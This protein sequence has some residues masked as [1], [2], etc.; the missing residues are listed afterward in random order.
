MRVVGG[1]PEDFAGG[2]LVRQDHVDRRA[3]QVAVLGVAAFVGLQGDVLAVVEEQV[4]IVP[5]VQ[6]VAVA[7]VIDVLGNPPPERVVR[8]LDNLRDIAQIVLLGDLGQLVAVVPGV[9]G[10]FTGGKVAIISRRNYQSRTERAL[11]ACPALTSRPRDIVTV[12]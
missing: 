4:D 1:R 2:V 7:V 12:Q 5:G 6:R 10:F 11:L 3:V 8:V 9:F